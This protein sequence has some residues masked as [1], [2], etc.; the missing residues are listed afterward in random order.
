MR[1]VRFILFVF[2]RREAGTNVTVAHSPLSGTG[3]PY[4]YARAAEKQTEGVS[5]FHALYKRATPTGFESSGRSNVAP[6][7]WACPARTRIFAPYIV[8][9]IIKKRFDKNDKRTKMKTAPLAA[10]PLSA[11]INPAIHKPVNPLPRLLLAGGCAALLCGCQLLTY[12][13][14]TGESFTRVSLGATTSLSSLSLEGSTNGVRRV[15]LRGYQ[16][17]S[18]QA[19]GAVTEAAVKAALQSAK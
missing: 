11:S 7:E 15:E 12:Q 13:S 2:R 6:D 19:L 5:G 17:D 8:K 3:L 18:S 1:P 10:V 4:T 9:A 14:P 16:N